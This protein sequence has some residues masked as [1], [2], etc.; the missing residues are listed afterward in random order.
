MPPFLKKSL[1]WALAITGF[2]TVA[3]SLCAQDLQQS[4][5]VPESRQSAKDSVYLQ[6]VGR[7]V[8]SSDALSAL[9][10]FDDQLYAGSDH[11]LRMLV[12]DQLKP[13]AQMSEPIRRLVT[14]SAALWTMTPRGLHQ[15]QSETWTEIS[16]E[17]VTDVTEHLGQII[18]ASGSSLLRVDGDRLALLTTSNAPFAITRVVSHCETLYVHGR[19]RLTYYDGNRIGGLNV[20]QWASDKTWDW[21]SLPSLNTRDTLS[22]GSRLYIAT[23]KRLGIIEYN[24]FTLQKK[25]DFY[26]RHLD[27]W[28]Q[29]RLGFTHKLEWDEGLKQYVREVSDND[30]GYT[31]NYLAAQAYRYAVTKD[32]EARAHAVDTFQAL[33]WLEAIPGQAQLIANL[34][35]WAILSTPAHTSMSLN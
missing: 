3:G 21:G 33:R 34:W 16:N 23:A 25:A 27:E 13:V 30:G 20:Y 1:R 11:G 22:Q 35:R 19:G 17:P 28:G 9:A 8:L 5:R 24:D 26:E 15:F 2:F 14:T 12:G 29:R 4:V 7:Q 10:V 6:E 32:P 18:V 31:G